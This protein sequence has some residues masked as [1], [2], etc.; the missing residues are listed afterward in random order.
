MT[1]EA[2]PR[3]LGHGLDCCAWYAVLTPRSLGA[4]ASV[5]LSTL[6]KVESA[7]HDVLLSDGLV[8]LSNLF[9]AE[10]EAAMCALQGSL[11]FCQLCLP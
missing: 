1:E 2:G 5:E 6:G 8:F 9:R 7:D 3:P 4:V 11:Y 10:L